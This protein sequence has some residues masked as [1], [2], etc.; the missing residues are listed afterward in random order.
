MNTFTPI[1]TVTKSVTVLCV[2]MAEALPGQETECKEPQ[3]EQELIIPE[4][5]RWHARGRWGGRFQREGTACSEVWRR[6]IIPTPCPTQPH[7]VLT[8][9]SSSLLQL[10]FLELQLLLPPSLAVRLRV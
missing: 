10:S 4:G 9:P 8:P 2:G 1:E 5:S 3:E 7:L 6:S